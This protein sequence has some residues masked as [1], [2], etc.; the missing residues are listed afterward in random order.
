MWTIY[1]S[2]NLSPLLKIEGIPEPF[3]LPRQQLPDVWWHIGVLD[4]IRTD[5]VTEKNS[6]SG[7]VILPLKVDSE[8]SIDIDSLDDLKLA[9]KLIRNV[10][11]VRP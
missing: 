1:K 2:G 11:C 7:T 4:A 3:N 8:T 10:E 6:L 9:R 5:I